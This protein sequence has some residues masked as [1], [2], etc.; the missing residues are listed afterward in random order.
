MVDCGVLVHNTLNSVVH[1]TEL[2]I[3][4]G[5]KMRRVKIGEFAD[6]RIATAQVSVDIA[7][8]PDDTVTPLSR[9]HAG[10]HPP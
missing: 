8:Q 4:E 6:S 1:D 3:T 5:G 10:A 7:L 2:V 9:A